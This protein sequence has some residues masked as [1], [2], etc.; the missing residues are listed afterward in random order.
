MLNVASM[1]DSATVR[2]LHGTLWHCDRCNS[3]ISIHSMHIVDEA[4]CAVC[5]DVPLDLCGN[6]NSILGLQFADA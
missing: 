6:F 3:F 5:V 1:G 4:F 2:Q